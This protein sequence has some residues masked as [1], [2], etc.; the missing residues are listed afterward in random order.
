MR[1]RITI[2]IS[3]I[4][5]VHT[6][7]EDTASFTLSRQDLA[8]YEF[9]NLQVWF[10]RSMVGVLRRHS[11]RRT[12]RRRISKI[13]LSVCAAHRYPKAIS[14]RSVTT[15]PFSYVRVSAR[16][17]PKKIFQMAQRALA[18]ARAPVVAACRC[19]AN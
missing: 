17:C 3:S 11:P 6:P 9:L 5:S 4:M 8:A 7:A 19:S 16:A 13:T 15:A 18:A 1:A 2:T 14:L 10:A 12:R